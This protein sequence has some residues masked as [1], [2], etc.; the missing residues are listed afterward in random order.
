MLCV[1]PAIMEKARDLIAS[2]FVLPRPIPFFE[3]RRALHARLKRERDTAACGHESAEQVAN[4]VH[5]KITRSDLREEKIRLF[6]FVIYCAKAS[7]RY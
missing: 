6:E 5:L 1:R 2:E 4:P 7:H 3:A